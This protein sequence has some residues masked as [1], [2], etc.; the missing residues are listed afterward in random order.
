MGWLRLRPG[1][2]VE[3]G[4]L[5]TPTEEEEGQEEEEDERE[6]LLVRSTAVVVVE[7]LLWGDSSLISIWFLR[8]PVDIFWMLNWLTVDREVGMTEEEEAEEEQD[9]TPE[10]E[11]AARMEGAWGF[12]GE[13]MGMY[14]WEVWWP[15]FW[16]C[17][18]CEEPCWEAD[19]EAQ[20]CEIW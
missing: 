3:R 8:G 20:G 16:C 4:V 11:G 15:W 7:L 9:D 1:P 17:E 5:G 13:L 6:P 12:V 2:P 18:V 10:E 19:H 14:T